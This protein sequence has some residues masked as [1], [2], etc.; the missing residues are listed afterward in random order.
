MDNGKSLKEGVQGGPCIIRESDPRLEP[1]DV[2]GSV[3]ISR[4]YPD[5][6][7]PNSSPLYP[8]S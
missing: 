7:A 8:L 1:L 3:G 2:R 5:V 6:P 4:I